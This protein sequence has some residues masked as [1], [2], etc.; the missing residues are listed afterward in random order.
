MCDRLNHRI[1]VFQGQDFF[2]KFGQFS[3]KKEPGTFNQ[4]VD[5]TLNNSEDEIFVTD[6]YN[7]RVQ[8]FTPNG[9]FLRQITNGSNVPFRLEDPNGIFFTPDDHLLVSSK[10]CVLIFKTNGTFVSAIEG[11]YDNTVRFKDCIGVIMMSDGKIVVTD[12]LRGTNRLIVF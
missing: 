5:L 11:T 12:G 1:Q 4:P 9:K 6:W 2:Y 3:I 8:V 10:N 7:N